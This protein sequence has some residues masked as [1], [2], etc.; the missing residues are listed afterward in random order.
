[1]AFAAGGLIY[2]F[3]GMILTMA[4]NVPMNEAL[5]AIGV[6][7]TAAEAQRIWQ[8]YSAT[9]QFWNTIRAILSGLTLALTGYAIFAM[10]KR[11]LW[12]HISAVHAELP[13]LV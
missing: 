1:M 12:L 4:V 3:G 9:W 7:E 6:P 5:A 10:N 2:L 11:P 13:R 8:D